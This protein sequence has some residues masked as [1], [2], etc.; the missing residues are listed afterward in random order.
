MQITTQEAFHPMRGHVADGT[1]INM[2]NGSTLII[3]STMS[4]WQLKD[5]QGIAVGQPTNNA[6]VLASFIESI[7]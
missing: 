6:Y 3:S 4:G 2:R 5:D 1:R 7:K